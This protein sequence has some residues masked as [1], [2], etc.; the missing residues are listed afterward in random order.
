MQIR[1][2]ASLPSWEKQTVTVADGVKDHAASMSVVIVA[3]GVEQLMEVGG[4]LGSDMQ[5]YRR[6]G[7]ER[8]RR[9]DEGFE[10]L[11]DEDG[12]AFNRF[13]VPAARLPHVPFR[14]SSRFSHG[15]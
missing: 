8:E 9:N 1:P 4:V 10:R 13:A 15:G 7:D 6:E 3:A 2:V 12:A 5:G 14:A 11:R